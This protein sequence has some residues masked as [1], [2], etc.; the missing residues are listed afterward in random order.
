MPGFCFTLGL[1]ERVEF[2][3]L[4]PPRPC[5]LVTIS[6]VSWLIH[7]RQP[8][9]C[10]HLL[11]SGFVY[12]VPSLCPGHFQLHRNNRGHNSQTTSHILT[13]TVFD[14]LELTGISF[15]P[16]F[17]RWFRYLDTTCASVAEPVSN[18]YSSDSWRLGVRDWYWL[19]TLVRRPHRRTIV[20]VC[21]PGYAPGTCRLTWCWSHR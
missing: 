20:H 3:L 1:G 21:V 16:R 6:A 2:R 17:L 7:V 10:F 15:F 13:G 12:N 9:V 4:C 8:S 19:K 11:R 5:G 18:I 14:Q